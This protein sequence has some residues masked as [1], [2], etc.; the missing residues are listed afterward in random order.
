MQV[1]S[2]E[3]VPGTVG[4]LV[5]LF[6]GLHRGPVPNIGAGFVLLPASSGR[7]ISL[8]LLYSVIH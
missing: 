1:P 8:D 2:L 6:K 4:S 5:L 7:A 3:Q